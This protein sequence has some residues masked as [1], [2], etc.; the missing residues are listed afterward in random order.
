MFEVLGRLSG[1]TETLKVGRYELG[2]RLGQGGCGAVFEAHDPKL[3]RGVA[4]KVVLPTAPAATEASE[5]LV[6][7]AQALAKLGHP[8]I[9]EVFDVG[10][11]MLELGREGRPRRGVYIVMERID[12]PTLVDWQADLVRS[13]DDILDAYV[14]EIGRAHV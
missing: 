5:R 3:D 4:I 2:R 6:R 11:D 9:V 12:G 8:N 13:A 14:Q 10:V 7:E 1:R